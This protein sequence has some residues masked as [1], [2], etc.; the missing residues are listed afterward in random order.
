MINWELFI[1]I[2][3]T[4]FTIIVAFAAL[5]AVSG[6]IVLVIGFI[7]S[8]AFHCIDWVGEQRDKRKGKDD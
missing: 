4:C 2:F 5:L 3:N 8:V 7:A 6:L 1:G